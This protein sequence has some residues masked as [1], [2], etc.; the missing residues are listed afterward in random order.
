MK[1]EKSPGEN[2][3]AKQFYM[4][5][6]RD[7][8]THLEGLYNSTALSGVM[9]NSHHNALLR[10]LFF[11]RRPYAPEELEAHKSTKCTLQNT[12]Q[13]DNTQTRRS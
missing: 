10:L 11:K 9:V 4:N 1:N 5:F 2:G 8:E 3:I 7:L 6:Y 12:A 13:N